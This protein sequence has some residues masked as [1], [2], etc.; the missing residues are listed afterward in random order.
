MH[1]LRPKHVHLTQAG[2]L[3]AHVNDSLNLTVSHFLF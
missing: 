3:D 1:C 2:I